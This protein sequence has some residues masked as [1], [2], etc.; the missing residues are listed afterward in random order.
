VNVAVAPAFTLTSNDLLS[1]AV[2]VCVTVS[3]FVTVTV[4]PALTGVVVNARFLIV[5]P[6]ALD[7]PPPLLHAASANT[8]AKIDAQTAVSRNRG[9]RK[10]VGMAEDTGG[11]VKSFNAVRAGV[12]GHA[13]R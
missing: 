3:L 7:P 1:S 11:D 12:R 5:T 9:E 2:T 8:S 10:C 13:H 6:D 4:E